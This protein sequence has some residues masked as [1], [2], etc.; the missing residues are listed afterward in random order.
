M[1]TGRETSPEERTHR[2]ATK[3]CRT[4]RDEDENFI[5]CCSLRFISKLL[6]SFS[7]A[8]FLLDLLLYGVTN[9]E[10]LRRDKNGTSGGGAKNNG[11]QTTYLQEVT[12][13]C[14]LNAE[15]GGFSER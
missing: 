5:T 3:E 10:F 9:Q 13:H 12:S 6:A 8:M 11:S 14:S 7:G 4:A 1:G 2:S 15:R